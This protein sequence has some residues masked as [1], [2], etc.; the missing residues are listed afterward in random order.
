MHSNSDFYKNILYHRI[1]K[2]NSSNHL[3]SGGKHPLGGDAI[4]VK[5]LVS[6]PLLSTGKREELTERTNSYKYREVCSNY[7]F[8]PFAGETLSP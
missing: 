4:C 2:R 1:L 6:S 7:L 8:T 5:T 3:F